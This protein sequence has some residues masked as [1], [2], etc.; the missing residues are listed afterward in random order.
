MKRTVFLLAVL[1]LLAAC[2]PPL[3]IATPTLSLP[4]TDTATPKSTPRPTATPSVAVPPTATPE[5]AEEP[6]I[7][8][9]GPEGGTII[10]PDGA[11]VL[12]PKGALTQPVDIRVAKAPVVPE[13]PAEYAVT[14]AGSAYEVAPLQEAELQAT[15]ELMLPLQRREGADE[16]LYTVLRW[17]STAWSDVGG[18]VE[19]DFI[20]VQLSDFSLFQPALG[21]QARRPLKFLNDGPYDARVSI[22]TYKP[23]SPGTGGR[24]PGGSW[25]CRAPGPPL[26]VERRVCRWLPLGGYSFTIEYKMS[27]KTYHYVLDWREG[28]SDSDPRDCSLAQ[29]IHFRTDVAQAT[30]G[31]GGVAQPVLSLTPDAAAATRTRAAAIPGG[32]TATATPTGPTVT[33]RP[34]HIQTEGEGLIITVKPGYPGSLSADGESETVLLV[35][36]VPDAACWGGPE[37]LDGIYIMAE[38]TLG[39]VS[40]PGSVPRGE[41][42]AEV[43][44]TAGT[45]HGQAVVTIEGFYCPPPEVIVFGVCTDPT[46][47]GRHCVARAV[48]SMD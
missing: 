42:P 7:E 22:A 27:E 9:V 8:Q 32:P 20:H 38:T 15:L 6:V 44:L 23:L 40:W 46:V 24:L 45:T 13:L 37:V 41:L 1:M 3:P 19:G 28:V 35:D 4:P 2:A 26:A 39:S 25:I 14:T 48:V 29:T 30:P 10:G 11:R 47:K 36:V 12:V 34:G 31:P 18:S 17:D 33:P 21:T 5:L 16:S 43:I